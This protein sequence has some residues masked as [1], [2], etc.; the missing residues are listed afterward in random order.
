MEVLYHPNDRYRCRF[1]SQVVQ[2]SSDGLDRRPSGFLQERL[3]TITEKEVSDGYSSEK[4]RPA[5]RVSLKVGMTFI[6]FALLD[7]NSISVSFH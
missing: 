5:M 6:N 2:L 3:I 7:V 1:L 4:L